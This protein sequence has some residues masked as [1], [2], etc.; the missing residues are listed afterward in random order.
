M[1]P[2]MVYM[3]LYCFLNRQVEGRQV[4]DPYGGRWFFRLLLNILLFIC[5]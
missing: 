2:F 5:I 1:Y 4:A 3:V